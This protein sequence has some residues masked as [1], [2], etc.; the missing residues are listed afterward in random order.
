M[1]KQSC[2]IERLRPRSETL[3]KRG[4]DEFQV[5][6]GGGRRDRLPRNNRRGGRHS[7]RGWWAA[8]ERRG[9]SGL[10]LHS[11]SQR[12]SREWTRSRLAAHLALRAG[13]AFDGGRPDL[14]GRGFGPQDIRPRQ[15]FPARQLL[16]ARPWQPLS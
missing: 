8:T 6:T 1:R 15:G 10:R 5:S 9:R 4:E 7:D 3:T 12:E 16:L 14:L 11:V 2:I 13:N